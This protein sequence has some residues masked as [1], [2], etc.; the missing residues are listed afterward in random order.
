MDENTITGVAIGVLQSETKLFDKN[1]LRTQK[2]DEGKAG[3]GA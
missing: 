3:N 1:N 2:I